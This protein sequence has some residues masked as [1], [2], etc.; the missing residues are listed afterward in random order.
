MISCGLIGAK[1]AHSYSPQ[2]H[3][4]FGSYPYKLYEL[5]E[6]EIGAFL[7][8]GDWTALNVTIPYKKTVLPFMDEVSETVR[9]TGSVNTIVKRPDG[10]LF[11]D[12][13]D[14]YGFTG[15]V[16]HSGIEVRGKKT[17][18]LGSG[19]ASVAVKEALRL[20]GAETVVIS[21]SGENNYANLDRHRDAE[22]IVNTTPVGMFPKNGEAPVDV[23][24]FPVLK[25]V[26]DLIYNPERTELILECE[27]TGIPAFNGLYMLVAQ[28]KKSS[29]LFTGTSILDGEIDRVCEKIGARMRNIVL[30]GMPGSGKSTIAKE[31]G[32]LTGR[33]VIDTD[34]ELSARCQCPPE[35]LIEVCG[36]EG[37]R[38][39]ES[40]I[41]ASVAKLSGIVIATGGGIVTRE[42]NYKPVRQNSF[43]VRILREL[44]LLAT[45]GRPLSKARPLAE[46]AAEREDFYRKFADATVLN[47][48][49]PE[50]AAA[51][52][53]RLAGLS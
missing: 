39:L 37:F 38:N 24:I 11:G 48:S 51:K 16:K 45:K 15:S 5:R 1:L 21:R 13:T 7:K 14:V 12:N 20:L 22:I 49:T 27:E 18:I 44:G 3:A 26:F 52:I 41:L 28:A 42:R 36:E 25:G 29:E 35:K 6:D 43:T 10:T 53:V 2:I 9:R 46:L 47:D 34:V 30:I 31:I 23:R 50:E 8:N 33:T 40:E 32:R 19:G 4:L 17:L